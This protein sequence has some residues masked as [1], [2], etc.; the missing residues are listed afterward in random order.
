[1][2]NYEIFCQ[3]TGAKKLECNF[4]SFLKLMCEPLSH[5]LLIFPS[6]TE[7]PE[8]KKIPSPLQQKLRGNGGGRRTLIEIIH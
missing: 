8:A 4:K 2:N 3:I 6:L 7:T 5:S 1:M